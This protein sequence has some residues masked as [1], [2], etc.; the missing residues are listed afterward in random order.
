M[1]LRELER[2]KRI[3]LEP[4]LWGLLLALAVGGLVA[5]Q[6]RQP[7][8]LDVGGPHDAPYVQGMHEPEEDRPAGGSPVD[9]RWTRG[10]SALRM[11]G[12][13]KQEIA[14]VFRLQGY[15]PDGSSPRLRFRVGERP[16]ATFFVGPAWQ[17][18][19][20]VLPREALAAGDLN[21]TL[22]SETF[23]PAGDARALGVGLDRVEVRPLGKGWVDPAW[24]LLAALL[25]TVFLAYLLLRRWGLGRRWTG[26][27]VALLVALLCDLLAFHRLSLTSFAPRLLLL[28]V[29]GWLLTA[30]ALPFLEAGSDSPSRIRQLWA[31]LLTGFLLRIGGM[32]YPQFRSSDLLFHVHRAEWVMRGTLFFTAEIPDVLL[33]APYPPGL[34]LLFQ[35]LAL[36]SGNLPLLM[37]VCGAA[38]DTAAGLLL[39]R[40]ARELTNRERPALLALLMRESAPV[41][42]LIFSWG[43]YTN[44]FSHAA[45]TAVLLLLCRMDH[46]DRRGWM[47]LAGACF[48]VLLGHFADSLLL[49]ALLLFALAF[50]LLSA[51]GRRA[52]PWVLAAIFCSGVA[53]LALYYTAPPIRSA[54]RGAFRFLLLERPHTASAWGNPLPQ[55]L[56]HVQPLLAIL[57]LPGLV[58]MAG[59]RRAWPAT[60][61]AAALST[62]ALFALGQAAFGFSSRYSLFALPVLALGAGTWSGGLFTRGKAGRLVLGVLLFY[63]VYDGLH[64]WHW[65]IAFGQR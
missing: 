24:G 35:P 50:G 6:V 56:S 14:L 32:V 36:F 27:A 7:F 44:L 58:L 42:Y 33:P 5:Y 34:Y 51:D 4:A 18:Y 60:V 63:L 1:A 10:L 61:L 43:N 46:E 62:A 12:L 19:A 59:R 52:V 45:A 31:V 17:D 65:T 25:G 9:F 30:I 53:A 28:L 23:L 26:A 40:L 8:A 15:R 13:G 21:L 2:W 64:V 16:L 49:G 47:L 20:L 57:A 37:Q 3:L 39:Y 22:E 11:P 48:L 38:L 29:W 55:F 41:T 54:L